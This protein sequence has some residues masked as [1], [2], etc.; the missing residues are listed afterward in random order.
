MKS[1]VR[2]SRADFQKNRH[3]P[4]LWMHIIIPASVAVLLLVYYAFSH[5]EATG[6][7][8]GLMELL[9]VGFPLIIG[10]ITS[11][12]IDQERSAGNFQELLMAREKIK[13][14]LSKLCM[15]LLMAL[16]SLLIA[17]GGFALGFQFILHQN[18]F[19]VSVYGQLI[20]VLFL[21][22]I[23]LYILHTVCSLRFGSGAS[24]G[25]GIG[26]SLISALLITGLGEGIW[27][28]IPC[29]WGVRFSVY[30]LSLLT[31]S[32]VSLCV[33]ELISGGTICLIATV[34]LF[35]FSIIWFHYFEGRS[36]N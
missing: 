20:I 12:A 36:E 9:G 16:G 17:I 13:S 35:V 1:F 11:M 2:F 4:M 31:H 34:L 28:W 30:N 26:E 23:F 10:I 18:Q 19:S 33:K 22:Q 8:Y 6:K 3:T 27:H 24:I 29:G 25:L 32:G 15:L 14:Y 5:Q 21:S 7:V